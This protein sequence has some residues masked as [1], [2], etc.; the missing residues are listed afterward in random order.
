MPCRIRG[1]VQQP[2]TAPEAPDRRGDMAVANAESAVVDVD[3][4]G[5]L[6]AVAERDPG[7]DLWGGGN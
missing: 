1:G 6:R 5:S 4:C 3:E 2:A 7:G